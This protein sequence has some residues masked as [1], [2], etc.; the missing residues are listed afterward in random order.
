MLE[1]IELAVREEN[2][3]GLDPLDALLLGH[4]RPERSETLEDSVC[5]VTLEVAAHSQ[6]EAGRDVR[7]VVHA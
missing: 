1:P 6:L 7:F 2:D 3:R 4:R 5:C